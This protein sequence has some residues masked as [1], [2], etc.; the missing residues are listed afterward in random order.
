MADTDPVTSRKNVNV[1]KRNSN[2]LNLTSSVRLP[3]HCGS[4]CGLLFFF[5]QPA[6]LTV[7]WR[8]EMTRE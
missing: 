3:S 8:Q 4:H 7:P 2:A 1:E 5:P 6:A